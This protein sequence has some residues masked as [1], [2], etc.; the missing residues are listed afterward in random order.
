MRNLPIKVTSKGA[1]SSHISPQ[2]A[3]SSSK[4]MEGANSSGTL[5]PGASNS[6]K[7]MEEVDL[8]LVASKTGRLHLD[9]TKL[10]GSMRR[11]LKS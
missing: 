6:S 9:K 11:N 1:S 7:P 5:P 3:S 4:P 8:K 2:G 10:S